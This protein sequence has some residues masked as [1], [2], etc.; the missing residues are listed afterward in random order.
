M[1]LNEKTSRSANAPTASRRGSLWRTKPL[2]LSQPKELHFPVRSELQ[3][4]KAGQDY[5]VHHSNDCISLGEVRALIAAYHV[6]GCIGTGSDLT[7]GVSAS[8]LGFAS[9]KSSP[10]Y[11]CIAQ[12][13]CAQCN[14]PCIAQVSHAAV[15]LGANCMTQQCR[16]ASEAHRS[17]QENHC[18][19]SEAIP[20]I[21]VSDAGI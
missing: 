18:C 14:P 8:R 17:T 5:F 9:I 2:Y 1:R 4:T 21:A 7:T 10:A 6:T 15:C 11:P 20:M 19:Y 12:M 16:L 3:S 13:L